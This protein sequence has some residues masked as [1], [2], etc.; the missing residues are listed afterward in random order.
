MED[1]KIKNISPNCRPFLAAALIVDG[2]YLLLRSAYRE[3]F[4]QQG[5]Y[6][7]GCQMDA[8]L[9]DKKQLK[10]Q[11]Y[12]KYRLQVKVGKYLGTAVS[13]IGKRGNCAVHLY[14]CSLNISNS[15]SAVDII[16][17][18]Y[19][20]DELVNLK[21]VPPD[22]ELA[23]RISIFDKA[24]REVSRITPLSE[25]DYTL[26]RVYYKC[27]LYY[28]DEVEYQDIVD[29]ARLLKSESTIVEIEKAFVYIAN[30]SKISLKDYLKMNKALLK[31]EALGL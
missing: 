22:G 7:P 4:A 16:P 6:F 31:K 3:K 23:M 24:Y 11:L 25:Y 10:N 18:L 15:I 30:K 27:L 29:F 13:N 21:F 26:A 9:D 28:R 12:T 8:K 14:K 1:K 20:A 5:F 17:C 2:K 19:K